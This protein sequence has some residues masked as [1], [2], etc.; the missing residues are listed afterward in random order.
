VLDGLPNIWPPLCARDVDGAYDNE[1]ERL[2]AFPMVRI[3]CRV[4][5]YAR[6]LTEPGQIGPNLPA[7]FGRGCVSSLIPAEPS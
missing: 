6:L 5:G 2:L 1:I 7:F 4:T 3:L